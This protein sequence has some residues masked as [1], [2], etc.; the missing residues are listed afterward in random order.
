MINRLGL[1][2]LL[3]IVFISISPSSGLSADKSADIKKAMAKTK[4]V[5]K[6]YQKGFKKI[7]KN[8]E[9][10]IQW[11]KL[12]KSVTAAEAP[13]FVLKQ[14]YKAIRSSAKLNRKLLC[15]EVTQIEI[16][17]GF[18]QP[19]FFQDGL[20]E[21]GRI[22]STTVITP[23]IIMESYEKE[24]ID[25]DKGLSLQE[26]RQVRIEK[27]KMRPDIKKIG[28]ICKPKIKI[29][30]NWDTYEDKYTRE[31]PAKKLKTV[32][33]DLKEIARVN[34]KELCKSLKE[35]QLSYG[36]TSG[37]SQLEF[38][39]GVLYAKSLNSIISSGTVQRTLES[40][41]K[42]GDGKDGLNATQMRAKKKADRQIKR[43]KARLKRVCGKHLKVKIAWTEFP[44]DNKME[45]VPPAAFE[46]LT[47]ALERSA[48]KNKK[49][50]CERIKAFEIGYGGKLEPVVKKD[51]LSVRFYGTASTDYKIDELMKLIAKATTS[52]DDT[53][54][55]SEDSSSQASSSGSS[56]S[57][58]EDSS[59]SKSIDVDAGKAV[60]DLF[61]F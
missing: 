2:S 48:R 53:V 61:G 15:Q 46:A 14:T 28:Q 49:A 59:S 27:K 34:K 51:T 3:V 13:V 5:L 30:V 7:C 10:S 29:I 45:Y 43:K 25:E 55:L 39:D 35:V 18:K 16:S 12:N 40:N 50:V 9:V 54:S 26:I 8:L 37:T 56:E 32:L 20:L 11:D 38:T 47:E 23:E 44:D 33:K 1:A 52:K 58:K 21:V 60:K 4:K 6:K 41:M 42:G 24:L 31:N 22:G 36:S 17:D 57:K 19:A